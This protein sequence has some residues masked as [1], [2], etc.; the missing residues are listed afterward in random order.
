MFLNTKFGPF[1][2]KFKSN[3]SLGQA[4]SGDVL[5]RLTPRLLSDVGV[6]K[7]G[8]RI[9]IARAI[10]CLKESFGVPFEQGDFVPFVP[11]AVKKTLDTAFATEKLFSELPNG[12]AIDGN[13][14]GG[15]SPKS[16]QV[17]IQLR[18]LETRTARLNTWATQISNDIVRL[19]K[20]LTPLL[21]L[22]DQIQHLLNCGKSAQTDPDDASCASPTSEIGS[23]ICP[24]IKVYY[25]ATGATAVGAEAQSI[26]SSNEPHALQGVGYK[27]FQLAHDDT[28]ATLLPRL[29]KK[30][31]LLGEWHKY[32]LF[33]KARA[34]LSTTQ[35]REELPKSSEICIAYDEPLAKM[36][37][38]NMPMDPVY[39]LKHI[40]RCVIPDAPTCAG[41]DLVHRAFSSRALPQIGNSDKITVPLT[42][43]LINLDYKL[44]PKIDCTATPDNPQSLLM[45][46]A[47]STPIITAMGKSLASLEL[48]SAKNGSVALDDAPKSAPF[49]LVYAIYDYQAER[50]SEVTLNVGDIVEITPVHKNGWV[51]VTKTTPPYTSGWVPLESLAPDVTMREYAANADTEEPVDVTVLYDYMPQGPNEVEAQK[52]SRLRVLGRVK[53]WL[54][55][56][57]PGD[58]PTTGWLPSCYVSFDSPGLYASLPPPV[59]PRALAAPQ[60]SQSMQQ[61]ERDDTLGFGDLPQLY[62]SGSANLRHRPARK[63]NVGSAGRRSTFAA[64]MPPAELPKVESTAPC[65]LN[66]GVSESANAT[67]GSDAEGE[68]PRQPRVTRTASGVSISIDVKSANS[69][70]RGTLPQPLRV[71]P[72]ADAASSFD[73]P[74]AVRNTSPPPRINTAASVATRMEQLSAHVA[75]CLE[76]RTGSISRRQRNINAPPP[77]PGSPEMSKQQRTP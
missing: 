77:P 28:C 17:S 24:P 43:Q 33:F 31:R 60:S 57:T 35:G 54:I 47:T 39:I 50:T 74:M 75:E 38:A 58:P 70:A 25:R 63:R 65:A 42:P 48:Q 37:M 44:L 71:S 27:S 23:E 9:L 56:K 30:F 52:G 19:R 11:K 45:Q 49:A 51:V 61:L 40:N 36:H 13:L 67:T 16:A 66:A 59:L 76:R 2:F 21:K 26:S 12:G 15:V 68:Q 1:S 18:T 22:Q 73:K 8:H 72:E 32:A 41:L 3:L 7:I 6:T 69:I 5:V 34:R 55:V 4:I 29:L 46:R 62:P 64:T 14:G 20:D 53:H 10:H